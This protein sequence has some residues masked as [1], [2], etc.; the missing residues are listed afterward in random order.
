MTRRRSKRVELG[1]RYLG[2]AAVATLGGAATLSCGSEQPQEQVYCTNA[3]G[4]VVDEDYCD[5]SSGHGGG[6]G[7]FFLNTGNHGYG[8]QPGHRLTGGQRFPYND[9]GARSRLGLPT[10]GKVGNGVA[11]GGGFGTGSGAKGGGTGASTGS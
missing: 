11:R 1:A 6:G 5:D 10:T 8:H 3:N 9:T 4:V 2:L 7:F